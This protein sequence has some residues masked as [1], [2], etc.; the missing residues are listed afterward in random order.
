MVT[1]MRKCICKTEDG[2][3]LNRFFFIDRSAKSCLCVLGLG[4]QKQTLRQDSLT[5]KEAEQGR[6]SSQAKVGFQTKSDFSLIP[7]RSAG[8]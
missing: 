4:F 7:K 8:T 6:D 1:K 2:L 5:S 3:L